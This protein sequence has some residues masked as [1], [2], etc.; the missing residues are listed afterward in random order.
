MIVSPGLSLAF[1]YLYMSPGK[2]AGGLNMIVKIARQEVIDKY[3]S[4]PLREWNEKEEEYSEH[5]PKTYAS[6]ILTLLSKS[7]RGQIKLWEKN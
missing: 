5:F 2:T 1:L 4:F 7:Y 6:Y 3:P